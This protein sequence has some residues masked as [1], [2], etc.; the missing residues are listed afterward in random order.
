M[1]MNLNLAP[2]Y[3]LYLGGRGEKNRFD[4]RW[5]LGFLGEQRDLAGSRYL[6]VSSPSCHSSAETET[7]R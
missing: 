5:N 4:L 7:L 1:M 6:E 3:R 2:R